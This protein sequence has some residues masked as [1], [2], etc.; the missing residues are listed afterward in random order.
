MT[1]LRKSKQQN[2]SGEE[3]KGTNICSATKLC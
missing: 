2:V 1:C 3:E